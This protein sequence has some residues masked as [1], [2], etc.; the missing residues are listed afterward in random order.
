[1]TKAALRGI[2]REKRKQLTSHE[3]EKMNDLILVNF[4][5]LTLPYIDYVHTY[6][7]SPKLGEPQTDP[8]VRYLQFKNPSLKVLVP[9]IGSGNGEM[10]HLAIDDEAEWKVN[11]FGISEP[12]SGVPVEADLI[13]LVLVPLLTFDLRGN[14]VGFGKGYYDRFLALCRKDVIKIG[15]S[16]F[17]PAEEIEDINEY[18]IPLNIVVTPQ[19]IYTF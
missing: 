16:F 6:L 17:E 4:Q 8:I 7:A 15:I 9:K 18:D 19:H 13:D 10:L 3:I 1:M 11:Q 12:S 14:R 5:K 2:Y